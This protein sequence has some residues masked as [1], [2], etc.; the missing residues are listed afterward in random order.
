MIE[1]DWKV[2]KWGDKKI[3]ISLFFFFFFFSWE[4]KGEMMEKMYLYK[5]TH[6]PLF[7]NDS[8]LKQ[9]KKWQKKKKHSPKFIRK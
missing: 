1:N 6:I 2:K 3:L 7:K 4:W 5:F 8:L 9:N